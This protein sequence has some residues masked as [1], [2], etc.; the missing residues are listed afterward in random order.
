LL[1]ES[2]RGLLAMTPQQGIARLR[3]PWFPLGHGDLR[4][5]A[6]RI[7]HSPFIAAGFMLNRRRT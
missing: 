2:G 3:K 1:G 7:R 5:V 6:A 4:R